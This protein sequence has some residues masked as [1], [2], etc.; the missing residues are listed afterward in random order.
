MFILYANKTDLTVRKKEP[1]TSGSANVYRA[2]FDFSADWDGLERVAVFKAGAESRSVLLDDTGQCTIPWEVLTKPNLPLQ[3]GVYGT[4]NGDTVLPTVWANL[5][6][7]QPGAAPGELSRPPTPGLWE[8]ELAKKAD[9]LDYTED[10]ELGLYSGDKLLSSVK[11][12]GGTGSGYGIGHGLKVKDGDL[13][14]VT[15]DDFSGDNTLPMTAAGVETVVGNI[16]VLL[17]TI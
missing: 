5:G 15:T 4:R 16:E 1:L 17:G 7:I 9:R 13:T 14:V 2:R 10:G 11:V 6:V 12:S 3:A 8:Q